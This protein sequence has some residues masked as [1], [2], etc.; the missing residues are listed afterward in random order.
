MGAT[1]M[2]QCCTLSNIPLTLIFKTIIHLLSESKTAVD[3]T[4]LKQVKSINDGIRSQYE[5]SEREKEQ[6][7][8]YGQVKEELKDKDDGGTESE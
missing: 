2:G 4:L 7:V 6:N 3:P 1:F 8:D 5:L